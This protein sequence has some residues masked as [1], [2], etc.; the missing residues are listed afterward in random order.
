MSKSALKLKTINQGE[1]L[2]IS[3]QIAIN[4]LILGNF[5]E[6]LVNINRTIKLINQ[7]GLDL[8]KNKNQ[9][10]QMRIYSQFI[11]SLYRQLKKDYHPS[12]MEKIP[13][14][15]ESHCLSFTHQNLSISSKIKKIQPVLIAGG[16]AWHFANN[17]NNQW[18]DSL[19]QQIKNHTYSDKVFI[20]FGEIDCRKDEGILN[21]A[22]KNDKDISEVCKKTIQGYLSYMEQILSPNY[23]KKYYFGIPAPTRKKEL[24]DELDIKRIKMVHLYNSILK[25][26]VLSR[27][28]YFLDVYNLTSSN[29]GENNNIYMCDDNH[30][31]PKCLSILFDN[32]LYRPNI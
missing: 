16:K 14:V 1:R 8:I 12:S 22:I 28:S 4:N 11:S 20:S 2:Q 10:N 32:Y 27:D 25:K 9:K 19:T 24:L 7:G 29:D 31:S 18:K 6:T 15:G 13:F 30:L 23:S 17:K 21:Y 3:L 5:D 26:E